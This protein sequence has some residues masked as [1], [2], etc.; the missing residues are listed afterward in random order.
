ML[1]LKNRWLLYYILKRGPRHT[2]GAA[3]KR[4]ITVVQNNSMILFPWIT[5]LLFFVVPNCPDLCRKPFLFCNGVAHKKK[6]FPGPNMCICKLLVQAPWI[7]GTL[8]G[9]LEKVSLYQWKKKSPG[10]PKAE[11]ACVME[12]SWQTNKWRW[13]LRGGCQRSNEENIPTVN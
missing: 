7:L 5:P 4:V 11:A 8:A 12:P 6:P 2:H 10:E 3:S 9:A 1:C 13:I